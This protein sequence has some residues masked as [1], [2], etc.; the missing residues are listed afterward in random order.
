MVSTL[1]SASADSI[2]IHSQVC[3]SASFLASG[4]VPRLPGMAQ[5]F[6]HVVIGSR[7]TGGRALVLA[8]KLKESV[9]TRETS[10][11]L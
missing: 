8:A 5:D 10:C 1:R 9:L 3:P 4:A 7:F 11:R 6:G 2:H